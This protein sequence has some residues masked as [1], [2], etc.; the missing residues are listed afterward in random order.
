MCAFNFNNSYVMI[1][2][3]DKKQSALLMLKRLRRCPW[4]LCC[5]QIP[6]QLSAH[7]RA[8]S[9]LYAMGGRAKEWRE[10]WNSDFINIRPIIIFTSSHNLISAHA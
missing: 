3:G 6:H 10:A 4:A 8:F 7:F 2:V 5:V 1:Q 9:S